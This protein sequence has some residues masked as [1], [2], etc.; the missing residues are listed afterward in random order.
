MKNISTLLS[1][2]ALVL[3]GILYYL[4]FSKTDNSTAVVK[5]G[6]QKDSSSFKVA[7]FDIDSL[8]TH[9]E[10][11]KDVS[12]QIKSRENAISSELSNLRN[13]FEKK[14]KEWQQRGPNMSQAEGEAAQREYGQ[15][16][17]RYEQRQIA[18]EQDLQKQRLDMMTDVRKKIEDYLL[19]YNK[20]KGYAYILSYEPG[21]MLYYRDSAYDI[22]SDVIAGLNSTYKKK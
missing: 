15:M 22:T 21:F 5:S 16:Q 6:V 13:S 11:F 1:I 12:T 17:Q 19:E 14:M 3:V 9:Y 20:G 18:L 4:H 2:L 10:Y 7:Y 8:Q